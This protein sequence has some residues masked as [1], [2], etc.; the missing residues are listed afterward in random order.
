M[1]PKTIHFIFGLGKPGDPRWTPFGLIQYLAV[2]SAAWRNQD[3]Q[4]IIHIPGDV[5]NKSPVC[6]SYWERALAL[7]NVCW[8]GIEP[9]EKIHG[10]PLRRFQH[11]SDVRR[12]QILSACGGVYLDSDTI[13]LRKFPDEFWNEHRVIMGQEMEIGKVGSV[14]LCNAVIFAPRSHP[15]IYLWFEGY[16]DFDP[17][18]W[19]E[20]SVQLPLQLATSDQVRVLNPYAFFWPTCKEPAVMFKTNLRLIDQYV[21][22]LWS[23]AWHAT[24]LNDITES[25]ILNHPDLNTFNRIASEVLHATREVISEDGSIAR[26][27]F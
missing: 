15:F 10:R 20:H 25:S 24:Y 6:T 8:R 11:K 13:T 16:R 21:V 14:G 1:I 4:I 2:K 19:N 9:I 18:E 17:K 5:A 7:P 23:S 3:C 12:L 26:T 22:H 27:M